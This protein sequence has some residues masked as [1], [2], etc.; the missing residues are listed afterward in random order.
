MVKQAI[1][2][3]KTQ[4]L[5]GMAIELETDGSFDNDKNEEKILNVISH[6][7]EMVNQSFGVISQ[8]PALLPLYRKMIEAAVAT[9]DN[10][11]QF[12]NILEEVFDK[13]SAELNAP[14]TPIK[15]SEDKMLDFQTQKM[16]RDFAIKREQN[17]IKREELN[18]KKISELNKIS[19]N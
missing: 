16:E 6:I 5:R 18:L 12:E 14:D 13:I 4:K 17:Q 1:E 15:P 2:L 7:N 11:R 3:L 8:Q 19:K 10:A 9:L